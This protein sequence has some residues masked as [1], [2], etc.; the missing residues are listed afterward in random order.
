M[1]NSTTKAGDEFE[2]KGVRYTAHT[3]TSEDSSLCNGCA[4]QSDFQA[5]RLITKRCSEN[6]SGGWE[7]F[8]FKPIASQSIKGGSV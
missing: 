5:C 6:S 7:F 1:S 2:H 8:V 4:F 3:V